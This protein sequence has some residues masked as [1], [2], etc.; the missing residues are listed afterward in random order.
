MML[1]ASG[2]LFLW[3]V[4]EMGVLPGDGGENRFGPSP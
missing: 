3:G 2:V 1:V 4:T